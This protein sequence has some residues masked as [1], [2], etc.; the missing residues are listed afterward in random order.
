[1][2][3]FSKNIGLKLK[4]GI[5]AQTEHWEQTGTPNVLKSIGNINTGEIKLGRRN[6]LKKNNEDV[7]SPISL[8]FV[9]NLEY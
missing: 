7:S 4:E 9:I 5:L 6:I 2:L 8:K 1:M 3:R